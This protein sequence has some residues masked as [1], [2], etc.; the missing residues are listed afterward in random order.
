MRDKCLSVADIVEKY[1]LPALG[2][3]GTSLRL[4]V[5]HPCFSFYVLIY[6]QNVVSVQGHTTLIQWVRL[7]HPLDDCVMVRRTGR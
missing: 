6:P 7:E 5:D 4:Q 3:P 2:P 1:W